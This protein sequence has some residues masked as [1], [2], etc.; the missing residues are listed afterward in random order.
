M[1]Q[2]EL[3]LV[4]VDEVLY[5]YLKDKPDGLTPPKCI[6]ILIENKIYPNDSSNKTLA[7]RHDLRELEKLYPNQEVFYTAHLKID[8][9]GGKYARWY[10]YRRIDNE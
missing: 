1:K 10:I 6:D 3:N 5:K 8:H 4:K 9:T 7:F 2:W